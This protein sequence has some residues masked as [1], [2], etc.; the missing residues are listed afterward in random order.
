MIGLQSVCG[1]D[2]VYVCDTR[3][4]YD[5]IIYDRKENERKIKIKKRK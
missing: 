1:V 4:R 2:T 3:I 5:T